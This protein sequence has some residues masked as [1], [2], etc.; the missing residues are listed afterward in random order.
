MDFLGY[1][2]SFHLKKFCSSF[3]QRS[4]VAFWK[5]PLAMLKLAW[6]GAKDSSRE[7]T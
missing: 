3:E 2:V 4:D 5:D 1:M 6:R 7:N